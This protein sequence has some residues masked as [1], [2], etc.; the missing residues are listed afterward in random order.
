MDRYSAV[1]TGWHTKRFYTPIAVIAE[2]C[3]VCPHQSTVKFGRD[4]RW[5]SKSP[6]SAYKIARRVTG[7]RDFG[8]PT[9]FL[10]A[11]PWLLSCRDR[12]IYPRSFT[13]ESAQKT[14]CVVSI[15]LETTLTQFFVVMVLTIIHGW[16]ENVVVF[17]TRW[18]HSRHVPT[19]EGR[20]LSSTKIIILE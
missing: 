11:Q 12:N 19:V 17:L 13:P 8:C 18:S 6:Q 14:H 1:T 10:R 20:M 9:T 7:F 4:F 15:Y 3:Q 2:N 16:C 5:R